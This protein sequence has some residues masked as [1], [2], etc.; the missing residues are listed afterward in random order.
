[1]WSDAAVEKVSRIFF[2]WNRNERI[3]KPP[4][5]IRANQNIIILLMRFLSLPSLASTL[6]AVL[7]NFSKNQHESDWMLV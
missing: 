2:M 1:M 3:V 4:L 6:Q 5:N 7:F